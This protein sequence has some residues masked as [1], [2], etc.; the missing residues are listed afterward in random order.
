MIRLV[1]LDIDGTITEKDQSISENTLF[2][3]R[4]LKNKVSAICLASGNVLPVM[5]GIKNITG[6]GDSLA[7][8]NGG[9]FFH[10]GNI[11]KKFNKEGPYKCYEKLHR[12]L[13]AEEFI[14]NRWRETSVSFILNGIHDFSEYEKEFNVRI[15]DSGYAKHIMNRDQSKLSAVEYFRESYGFEKEEVLVCGDGENDISMFS[16]GY[17]T[18][19]PSNSFNTLKKISEYVSENSYGKGLIEILEY[20]SLL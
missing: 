5:I 6:I 16:G 12:E 20:Y 18:G 10:K 8:E 11:I 14:T 2:Y 15:E 1:V 13:G 4:K 3:L 9:M 19:C 7:A 17:H